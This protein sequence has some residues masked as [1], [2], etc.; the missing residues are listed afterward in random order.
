MAGEDSRARVWNVLQFL[1]GPRI[2]NVVG[3]KPVALVELNEIILN[4]LDGETASLRSLA[5]VSDITPDDYTN[6]IECPPFFSNVNDLL[7]PLWAE[8]YDPALDDE[9]MGRY[10]TSQYPLS[11]ALEFFRKSQSQYSVCHT[12]FSVI[13]SWL[14]YYELPRKYEVI[15]WS[16]GTRKLIV[17]AEQL[18]ANGDQWEAYLALTVL[19][20]LA[21][22]KYEDKEFAFLPPLIPSVLPPKRSREEMWLIL[23]PM[24]PQDL[25]SPESREPEQSVHSTHDY[26]NDPDAD[27]SEMR[28][29]LKWLDQDEDE[30]MVVESPSPPKDV[31]ESSGVTEAPEDLDHEKIS[32]ADSP[33]SPEESQDLEMDLDTPRSSEDPL[34]SSSASRPQ[35]Q[36]PP[37]G[38]RYRLTCVICCDVLP[39]NEKPL[40]SL[41][42]RLLCA[43]CHEHRQKVHCSSCNKIYPVTPS[44]VVADDGLPVCPACWR[45]EFPSKPAWATSN[46]LPQSSSPVVQE[47]PD[48]STSA[49]AAEI[50]K[51]L[52]NETST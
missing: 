15:D 3:F 1:M 29:F 35:S 4:V 37:R 32:I 34:T 23:F 36:S 39:S 25:P 41:S 49:F 14:C 16:D 44:S 43:E 42:G 9:E 19:K 21:P 45:K 12:L 31:P 48:E 6:P 38:R 26:P 7:I 10:C 18:L 11:V 30:E 20:E 17:L 5:P 13:H 27:S 28:R 8:Q 40:R 51:Y 24:K 50:L 22:D 33:R 2:Q 52:N 46:A 47:T